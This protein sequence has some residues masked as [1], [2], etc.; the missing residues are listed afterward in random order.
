MMHFKRHLRLLLSLFPLL[1][2]LQFQA[3][4]QTDLADF[5]EAA[6]EFEDNKEA[7]E[8]P[9]A[10]GDG[11]GPDALRFFFLSAKPVKR[12]YYYQEGEEYKAIQ[13][14]Y[15]T[16]GNMHRVSARSKLELC[17][18]TTQIVDGEEVVIYVPI[19][20]LKASNR[21]N[22][23]AM[24]LPSVEPVE[25]KV[26]ALNAIDF[27]K[28]MFPYNQLTFMNILPKP[29]MV[30]L[31]DQK[32][33]LKPGQIMRSGYSIRRKGVGY[34]KVALAVRDV[35]GGAK[36]LYNQRIAVYEDERTIAIPIAD[37]WGAPEIEV[38]TYRDSGVGPR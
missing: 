4:A 16:F 20:Q 13:A 26:I 31:E 11:L 18:K 22:L 30:M 28:E 3:Q 7:F 21:T 5:M 38:L 14:A 6:K 12:N 10:V 19:F 29:V 17:D 32:T 24:F 27:S 36:L 15:N 33:V 2:L 37:P 34:L 35:D 23:F 1:C 8:Q 25:G 9:D